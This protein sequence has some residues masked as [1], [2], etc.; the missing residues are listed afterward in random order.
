MFS[1][2][3]RVVCI[4]A[5]WPEG[6]SYPFDLPIQVSKV[7]TI[8]AIAP[9]GHLIN[10]YGGRNTIAGVQLHEV[11]HP[12]EDHPEA[13]LLPWYG[14]GRFRPLIHDPNTESISDAVSALKELAINCPPLV[15]VE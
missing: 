2:N 15:G 5:T 11:G 7:Y 13:G 3:E 8:K 12:A 4:W 14:V 10:K 9:A 1:V 6:E